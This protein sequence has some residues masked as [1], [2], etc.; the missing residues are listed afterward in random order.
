DW[1]YFSV[2]CLEF[3]GRINLMKGAIVLADAV[4]TVSPSYAHEVTESA[5]LG[6]GLEGVLRAKGE[7]FVG[8]L[9]GADYNEWNPA[10]DSHIAVRYAPSSPQDKRTC[11][12]ALRKELGLPPLDGTP[13]V[14]MVTRMT[15]QKGLDLLKDA[16]DAVMRLDLQ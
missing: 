12:A 13:I 2:D 1:S 9:N 3:H 14:G 15:P 11:G 10:T 7:H 5:E 16:F 6:F 8:I 4:S